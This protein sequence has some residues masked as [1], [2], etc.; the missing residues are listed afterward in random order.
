MAQAEEGHDVETKEDTAS[1][2][3]PSASQISPSAIQAAVAARVDSADLPP[4]ELAHQWGS[5]EPIA[6]RKSLTRGPVQVAG[7]PTGR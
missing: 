7:R 4:K 2:L 5:F 3:G 1:A 6:N